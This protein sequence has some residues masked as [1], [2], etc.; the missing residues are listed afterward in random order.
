MRYKAK[1]QREFLLPQIGLL[2]ILLTVGWENR[3][4]QLFC[5]ILL[6]F[7]ISTIFIKYSFTIKENELIYKISI[8]NFN[9]YEKKMTSMNIK[10]IKFKRAGLK[11]K[12]AVIRLNKGISIRISLFTPSNVFQNLHTFSEKNKIQFELSKDYKI[13]EKI[14]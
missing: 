14:T 12:L 9:I 10:K 13:L 7:V 11:T 3:W 6:T 2:M 8:L 4:F 1:A 5:F